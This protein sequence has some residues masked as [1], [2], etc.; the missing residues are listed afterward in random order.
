MTQFTRRLSDKI[1]AAFDQACEQRQ[2]EVAEHLVRALE[3][4]L[5][6]ERL[7]LGPLQAR[8]QDRHRLLSGRQVHSV[9]VRA[10]HAPT[11]L[12]TS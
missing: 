12:L 8:A 3:L 6:R 5:T 9:T 7:A 11:S 2:L 1:L 4:T 10:F